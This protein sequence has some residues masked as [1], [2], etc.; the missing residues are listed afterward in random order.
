M[1]EWH[2][3]MGVFEWNFGHIGG[4]WTSGRENRWEA[5]ITIQER[6]NTG[7]WTMGSR[8]TMSVQSWG[9][10]IPGL[11]SVQRTTALSR[12]RLIQPRLLV[13]E[14][15][16]G[17]M[18]PCRLK[19]RAT[20]LQEMGLQEVPTWVQKN[21]AWAVVFCLWNLCTGAKQTQDSTA[22]GLQTPT[23]RLHGLY[24]SSTNP[25][26]PAWHTLDTSDT[27]EGGKMG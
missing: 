27:R 3:Q 11:P 25:Q 15:K 18:C 7:L 2:Q 8:G 20:W 9:P 19:C 23:S 4:G 13:S 12:A 26:F 22:R 10:W 5:L 1:R 17:K 24:D 16:T 6:E 21:R 14:E